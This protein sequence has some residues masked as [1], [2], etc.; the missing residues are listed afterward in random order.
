[1]SK[2]GLP[3]RDEGLE[4]AMTG[5]SALVAGPISWLEGLISPNTAQQYSKTICHTQSLGKRSQVEP[6]CEKNYS[7]LEVPTDMCAESTNLGS[8]IMSA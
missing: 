2:A 7:L 6:R 4:P 5:T 1:M 3:V 8:S